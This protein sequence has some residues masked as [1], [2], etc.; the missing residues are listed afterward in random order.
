M[1]KDILTPVRKL[2]GRLHE[3]R[4]AVNREQQQRRALRNSTPDALF[5]VGTPIHPNIGDSAIVLAETAFLKKILPPERKLVELPEEAFCKYR[6]LADR[7]IRRS[8]GGPVLWHG[9]GN[10]GDLWTKQERVRRE[11][12]SEF[13]EKRIIAFPQ[14]IYYSDTEKGKTQA[15]ASIPFY[16][17]RIGLTL[18]AR[19]RESYEIMKSLY[20]E[21]DIRLIPDIVLSSSAEEFGVKPQKREG[22]LM[23]LRG[24]VEKAVGDDFW[25][26][27]KARIRKTGE[28]YRVTDM[29]ADR[30]IFMDSRAEIVRKKMQ[31]FRG[32]KLA[33]TDRLHGMVFA[34][35]TGTPCM[36][37]SNYNHKVRS[38][39]D[40]IS[41]LPYIRYVETM[42][43]AER[44]LPELL[45]MG[46]CEYDK[47]PLTPYYEELK[48]IILEAC[49]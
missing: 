47:S 46:N 23:C 18:T 38:T 40:W 13:G 10:M 19:E 9:G 4:L 37:F 2:H 49:Q 36:V 33:V 12:I 8:K 3:V 35:L 39:Y 6:E 44:S 15:K 31:E 26:E 27:L 43:D 16:N 32:A 42:E 29:G 17:G 22:V 28:S 24:D 11:A 5:L 48:S 30:V 1:S 21:T 20:P 7:S 25:E 14:T 45:K 34:A 41:Y